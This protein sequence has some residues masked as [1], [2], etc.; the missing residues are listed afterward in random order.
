MDYYPQPR[1]PVY[2]T[3]Y[4][5]PSPTTQNKPVRVGPPNLLPEPNGFD[6]KPRPFAVR[7]CRTYRKERLA[8][9]ALYAFASIAGVLYVVSSA[10]PF[11][12]VSLVGLQAVLSGRVIAFLVRRADF[13]HLLCLHLSAV[14]TL[15][16]FL[17]GQ[18]TF[19]ATW[20]APATFLFLLLNSSFDTYW[21]YYPDWS[22]YSR[23]RRWVREQNRR[24]LMRTLHRP[25]NY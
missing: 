1:P 23:I 19:P 18:W 5:E 21:S 2:G 20:L 22:F 4:D 11:L 14:L 3:R 15:S 9:A 8:L 17:F 24:E 16:G 12:F 6:G 10:Q 7:L 13:E 25:Y